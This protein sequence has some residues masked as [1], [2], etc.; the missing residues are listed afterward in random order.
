MPSW[1]RLVLTSLTVLA[2]L[3]GALWSAAQ[4][5]EPGPRVGATPQL[6]APASL[7]QLDGRPLR[8][9]EVV[10]ADTG[11]I[12][13]VTLARV[14]LGQPLSTELARRAMLELSGTSRYAELSALAL[15]SGD[16]VL[17]RLVVMPRYVIA[18]LRVTGPF[19]DLAETRRVVGVGEGDELTPRLLP[20]LVRRVQTHYAE[21][22]FP[23]AE[24][25]VNTIPTDDPQ[26][27]VLLIEVEPG[28]VLRVERR[29][30]VVS[31]YPPLPELSELASSYP[32]RTGDRVDQEVLVSADR[33]LEQRLR[34][35]GW[36][37]ARVSHHMAAA[38]TGQ[39]L[40]VVVQAGPAIRLRFEQNRHFDA[41]QLTTA[42]ELEERTD[43]DP[44]TL[45]EALTVFYRKRGFLDVDITVSVRASPRGQT[46][47]L[48]FT[49]REGTLVRVRGREYPCLSGE[50]TPGRVSSE[51][52]GWLAQELPGGGV[53][54]PVDA[55]AVDQT[56]GPRAQ[57]GSRAVSEELDPWQVYVPDV[58]EAALKRL[59]ELYRSEGYL[60]AT[61]GPV[62]VL[63]RRCAQRSPAG[64]CRPIGPLKRAPVECRADADGLPL[65]EPAPPPGFACESDPARGVRC[66]P[67]LVLE[68]PIK[69]GPRSDLYDIA[70]EGNTE[71]VERELLQVSEL[72]T[73]KPASQ[74]ELEKARRRLLDAY[75]EEGFAFAQIDTELDLSSDHTRAR[76]RYVISERERVRVT[77][78][79]IR[80]AT[81]TS[82]RLIRSRVALEKGELYRRSLVRKTEERLATLG[83]FSTVT[84]GFEDPT[85]PA[86]EKMVV[87]TVQEKK[88]QYLDVRPGFSTGEGFRTS[89]EYGHRNLGGEAIQLTLRSQLGYLPTP[90]ILEDDVR[91]KYEELSV[92]ERLERRNSVILEFPE[93]GLGPLFRF[94]VEG[95]DVRDNARDFGLTRDA[96]ILTLNYRP[97]RRFS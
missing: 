26:R 18:N 28:A 90:L 14:R 84:V 71:L 68:I 97:E 19:L 6:E 89:F 65:E 37:H 80:G 39:K 69:L 79:V 72:E 86:R 55:R 88:P 5:T 13:P 4:P 73:G 54:G 87:I 40:E 16:G 20:T 46:E 81:R 17:L 1:H 50:R 44:Q 22:G 83:V 77:G 38:R 24:V 35:R 96:V 31:P 91:R 11:S 7:G 70:F 33:D 58:Y 62:Y 47:E 61:V 10:R 27:V 34:A 25:R 94:S 76:V 56:L 57:T 51:I 8:R 42:L 29:V 21:R 45:T 53:I 60:S 48:L 67:D 82:E 78:I 30:L 36:F 85:V 15:P 93:I 64:T 52:D 41:S 63:R 59:Q 75:A 43:R 92:G 23:L 49:V 66:E 32:V 12:E 2:T 3:C 9:I 95:V 74:V